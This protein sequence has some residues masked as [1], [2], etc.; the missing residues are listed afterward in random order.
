MKKSFGNWRGHVSSLA[1]LFGWP[2]SVSFSSTGL[3][4]IETANNCGSHQAGLRAYNFQCGEAIRNIFKFWSRLTGIR[5]N[6]FKGRWKIKLR[7]LVFQDCFSHFV[8]YCRQFIIIYHTDSHRLDEAQT[9][10]SR[11]IL[12]Y[13]LLKRRVV[14]PGQ[15][16]VH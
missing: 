13:L 4:L 5:Q 1:I 14:S 6:I 16:G 7:D 12:N 11:F 9:Q 15:D 2:L 8:K 3:A 10:L